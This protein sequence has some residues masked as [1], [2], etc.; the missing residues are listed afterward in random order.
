MLADENPDPTLFVQ[1]RAA[2]ID[3]PRFAFWDGAPRAEIPGDAQF[4]DVGLRIREPGIDYINGPGV[5]YVGIR[6]LANGQGTQVALPDGIVP[7]NFASGTLAARFYAQPGGALMF[8]APQAG[9]QYAAAVIT[10]SGYLFPV[11]S[12]SLAP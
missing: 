3:V 7:I 11:G 4:R 8:E 12:P 6:V 9:P 5:Q 10:V 2:G 1:I